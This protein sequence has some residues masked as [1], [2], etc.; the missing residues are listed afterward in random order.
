MNIKAIL[1]L[2]LASTVVLIL[3]ACGARGALE[4]QAGVDLPVKAYAQAQEQSAERLL[5]SNPQAR[6]NRET[7]IL[8]RS[9]IRSEDPFDL[10]PESDLPADDLAEGDL[11]EG[12]ANPTPDDLSKIDDA[13]MPRSEK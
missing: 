9:T 3:S 7:E 10:P 12:D 4:P 6:P 11:A 1:Y 13:V 5:R 8:S 2:S